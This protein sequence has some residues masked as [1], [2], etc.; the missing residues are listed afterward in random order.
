[1]LS[2][3]TILGESSGSEGATGT[4]RSFFASAL[5]SQNGSSGAEIFRDGAASGGEESLACWSL[6]LAL[7]CVFLLGAGVGSCFIVVRVVACSV[8]VGLSF[9]GAGDGLG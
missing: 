9:C 6:L 7:F 3:A 1:M 5:G 8:W 2:A 4:S